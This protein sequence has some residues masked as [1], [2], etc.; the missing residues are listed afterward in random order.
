[1]ILL[2]EVSQTLLALAHNILRH[3]ARAVAGLEVVAGNRGQRLLAVLDLDGHTRLHSTIAV[4][5]ADDFGA[6]AFDQLGELGI[7]IL[8]AGQ[9][10]LAAER[11][12]LIGL[13]GLELL[14]RF[15]QHGEDQI[16]RADLRAELDHMELVGLSS[17]R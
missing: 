16:L 11:A 2:G 15:L 5:V 8:R 3:E 12:L 14:S 9:N 17:L 7:I 6:A 4:T 13:A 10:D 1:M